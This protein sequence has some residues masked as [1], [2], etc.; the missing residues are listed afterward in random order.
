MAR[1]WDLLGLR[2][3]DLDDR[4]RQSIRG[5][6][7]GGMRIS[8]IRAGSPAARHGMRIGDILVGLDNFQTLGSDNLRYILGDDRV[9]QMAQLSFQI[10]RAGSPQPLQGN[11]D[12]RGARR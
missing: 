2:L 9:Q 8:F 10:V 6:Y 7:E 11:M 4:E 5:R 12:L 3:A 1:I